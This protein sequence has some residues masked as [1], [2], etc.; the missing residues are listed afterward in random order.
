MM[1]TDDASVKEDLRNKFVRNTFSRKDDFSL[2]C[3]E[4]VKMMEFSVFLN[5]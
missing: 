2:L 4:L 3:R 5:C 1:H